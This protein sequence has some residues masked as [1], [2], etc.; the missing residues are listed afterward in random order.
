ML[1][2]VLLGCVLWAPVRA[3]DL[4]LVESFPIETD[5]D[6]PDLRG[7][8]EV[9]LEMIGRARREILWQTFYLAHEKRRPTEPVIAAL[10]QAA[11]RGVNVE[12]LVD[13]KFYKTYPETLDELDALDNIAVRKSSVGTWFGGVMHAKALF[14]DGQEGFLGSQNLDWRSME[15]IRELGV[16]FR[17]PELTAEYVKAFQWEWEHAGE[18]S[19]PAQLADVVSSP[20]VI[21]GST[22]LPTFSPNAL[23]G[24]KAAGD[25]AQILKLLDEAE[26]SIDVALLTYSPLDHG[27]HK[28]YPD[29]DNALRRADVRGV[30][31]RLLLSHWVE[32]KPGEDHLRSLD[33]L[34]NVEIRCCRI[35]SAQEGE[36]PFARVHHSKYLVTDARQAWLGT[37][38]WQ[39]DYFHSSRNY[40]L[41]FLS[42]PIPERLSRLFEFDWQ[43][44]TA[45]GSGSN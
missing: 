25:E 32:G 43:R 5:F 35:P 39:E 45:L 26:T 9:W 31:V 37:S 2:S 15:Q 1:A 44:G 11:A 42:G 41:V 19:P 40:G 8:S 16:H 36:I 12:L 22:V 13:P 33:A 3:Q 7:P 29:L 21:D 4:E 30:K 20:T 38:N 18:P 23:N 14:V 34:D 6:Q 28:Y 27:G 24:P 17:S 10:K